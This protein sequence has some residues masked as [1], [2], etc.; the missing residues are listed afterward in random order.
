M[1]TTATALRRT[2]LATVLA[3]AAAGVLA[4]WKQRNEMAMPAEPAQWPAFV[5]PER[6]VSAT[7]DGAIPDGFPVKVKVSSGIFHVPGG[8]FYDRT[9]PDRWYATTGAAL[10]DGYRQSKT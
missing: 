2:A 3:L 6:W 10:A 8:R 7:S 9:H 5:A 4:W 1:P